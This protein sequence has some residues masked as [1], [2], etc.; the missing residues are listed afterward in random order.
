MEEYIDKKHNKTNL[1][2][3]IG[4]VNTGLDD[5]EAVLSDIKDRRLISILQTDA[6]KVVDENGERKVVSVPFT[7]P[8]NLRQTKPE[9]RFV[10]DMFISMSFLLCTESY[11]KIL[12]DG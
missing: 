7:S 12:Q 11:R 9:V 10:G 2:D 3:N 4:P 1:I 8:E 5:N 6:F